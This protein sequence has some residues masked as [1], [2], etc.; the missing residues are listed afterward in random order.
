MKINKFWYFYFWVRIFYLFFTV[1][2]YGNLT[3]LGDT[4][5]YLTSGISISMTIFYN[6]TDLMT[7]L[8]GVFGT[9][10]GGH[11]ILSNFPFT[12]ISFFTIKWAIT[13]IGVKDKINKYFLFILL[14][15]PNFCIWTSI[16]SKEVFGLIF[17]AIF[18]VLIVNFF[19]GNFKLRFRDLIG[20]YICFLFKPQYLPFILQGLLLIFL[21]KKSI[22]P[23]SKLLV[24]FIFVVINLLTLYIFRNDIG[25]MSQIMHIYF[26]GGEA[27]R[28]NPFIN[29]T[30]FF[31]LAP[32]GMF[33]AFFGPTF[34]EMISS[35]NYFIAG[36]ESIIILLL[37]TFLTGGVFV[38]FTLTGKIDA[39]L[40]I[41]SFFIVLGICFIHYPFGIFN[42]GSA[43]R[44]RTNFL[45]IFILIF[46]EIYHHLSL[47]Y[48]T[49]FIKLKKKK[50]C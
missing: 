26:R 27:T 18:G 19:N 42:P 22:T 25:Q 49:E 46:L 39:G 1:L 33:L 14:S 28:E 12:L 8:G 41:G 20:L 6:S 21:L 31:R 23:S 50:L 5:K 44:Y 40:V 2:V 13:E 36:M 45:F 4:E 30:D 24:V 3:T 15:L 29:E 32:R 43:I 16:C 38:R 35:L 9:L 37:F 47:F 7:F 17:S 10:L 11:N 48:K 34:S